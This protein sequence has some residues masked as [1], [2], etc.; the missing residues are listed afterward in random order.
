MSK[1]ATNDIDFSSRVD[2][3]VRMIQD[4]YNNK[5]LS[6]IFLILLFP[7]KSGFTFFSTNKSRFVSPSIGL[8]RREK[9]SEIV[10]LQKLD[11][12]WAKDDSSELRTALICFSICKS[13][14]SIRKQLRFGAAFFEYISTSEKTN[15][16]IEKR[17][18]IA[19]STRF[20]NSI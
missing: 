5:L 19:N 18:S 10:T 3:G 6:I 13:I 15:N 17:F 1:P 9:P 7:F 16:I 2:E 8:S 12:Q 11:L 14:H 20:I 4:F